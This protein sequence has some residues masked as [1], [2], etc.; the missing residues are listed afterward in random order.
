[1]FITLMDQEYT[2]RL[3]EIL[4]LGYYNGE[5]KYICQQLL[6]R[7]LLNEGSQF[8]IQKEIAELDSRIS[9]NYLSDIFKQFDYIVTAGLGPMTVIE[10]TKERYKDYEKPFFQKYGIPLSAFL[11]LSAS[12][13]VYFNL[14]APRLLVLPHYEYTSKEEYANP[15]FLAFPD[16]EYIKNCKNI[17]TVSINEFKES[18]IPEGKKFVEKFVE[19]YSFDIRTLKA[20][21]SLRFKE[22]PL[23][24]YDSK[25]VFIDPSLYL[26]YMPH[27]IHLMLNDC[28]N[29]NAKKG[30]VFEKIALDLIEKIP[31]STLENRNIIYDKYELDGLINL[32][33]S[34][35]FIECK[36]RNISSESLLG[37]RNKISKDIEKAIK[38]SIKQGSRAI[39]SKDSKELKK[40]D[41]KRQVGIL[42]I[43]EGIFPNIRL[44]KI[45]GTNPID[46]CEYPV[47]VLNYFELKKILEQP[48]AHLFEEFLIWRSQKNMPVYAFDECDYWAFFN[49]NYRKNKEMKQAFKNAQERNIT[50]VYNSRRFNKKDYSRK[51]VEKE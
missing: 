4:A 41:I 51:I 42:V 29:Y 25:M 27:K 43:L 37:V 12:L 32:R 30:K 44:P 7:F 36:S 18:L 20:K 16:K 21:P 15:K 38:D 8:D 14:R 24:F 2:T 46:S 33:R 17:I 40:Y 19:L 10:Y 50:I 49:D 31:Y 39:N 23:F 22:H 3:Y 6:K 9:N 34:T 5:R 28:K 11:Y 1:M 45:I 13:W 48:D 47:C 35:W 26:R